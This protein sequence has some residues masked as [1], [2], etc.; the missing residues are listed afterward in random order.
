MAEAERPERRGR[1]RGAGESECGREEECS[2]QGQERDFPA[3]SSRF[4]AGFRWDILIYYKNDFI[5][6]FHQGQLV[7]QEKIKESTQS[8]INARN[9]QAFLFLI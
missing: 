9:F 4:G 8:F 3:S 5:N 1:G 7:I 6:L 2:S